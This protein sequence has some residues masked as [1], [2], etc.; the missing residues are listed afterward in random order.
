MSSIVGY[1]D[2][3]SARIPRHSRIAAFYAGE[4][5]SRELRVVLPLSHAAGQQS[6]A[7]SIQPYGVQDYLLCLP[8][9]ALPHGRPKF[10]F[11]LVSESDIFRDL[12]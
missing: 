1:P 12:R 2:E 5:Q 8:S 7:F 3:Q 4:S 9:S 10:G 6:E 11:S